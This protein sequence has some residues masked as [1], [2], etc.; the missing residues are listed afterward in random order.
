MLSSRGCD[1]SSCFTDL[2]IMRLPKSS[3]LLQQIPDR[4]GTLLPDFAHMDELGGLPGAQ[5]LLLGQITVQEFAFQNAQIWQEA[6]QIALRNIISGVGIPSGPVATSVI[7]ILGAFDPRLATEERLEKIAGT[8]TNALINLTPPIL[9]EAVNAGIGAAVNIVSAVPFI[10]WAVQIFWSFGKQ[11]YAASKSDPYELVEKFPPSR[12][13]PKFD[14]DYLNSMLL[15]L[16]GNDW[17]SLFFPPSVGKNAS[18]KKPIATVDLLNGGKRFVG[19]NPGGKP[20][21]QSG[22]LLENPWIGFVPGTGWL[23]Q[24]IETTGSH[25]V[26]E[27]GA[28]L[29]PS[30][31]KQC[32]WLW[33][34]VT[35]TASPAAFT[36]YC[37]LAENF[38]QTYIEDLRQAIRASSFNAEMKAKVFKAFD[39]QW[40][41]KTK[42]WD[43]IFGWGD[44]SK[45]I[46]YAT[47]PLLRQLRQRQLSLCDTINVAYVDATFGAAQDPVVRAKINK[48]QQDLLEHPAVCDV[49]LSG[50]QDVLLHDEII[51]RRKGYNCLVAGTNSIALGG[52]GPKPPELP[53]G[54]ATPDPDGLQPGDHTWLKYA[55][56]GVALTGLAAAG[57]YCRKD[58]QKVLRRLR[59]QFPF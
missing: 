51:D 34:Q 20:I 33:R 55:A 16:K 25:E 7:D 48:R 14:N 3:L 57:Y 28:T 18:W 50:V 41:K 29:L 2:I 19:T 11:A 12:F 5:N 46:E 1:L 6:G 58:L 52:S 32:A 54:F 24:A 49:D 45:E 35:R 21:P 44:G 30:S 17:S 9:E 40:N 4:V 31:Q 22:G 23:H 10:G 42:S 59:R 37:D 13:S 47:G 8:V 43:T 53:D 26:I 38:W 36:I 39:R 15:Q 27:T 56:G